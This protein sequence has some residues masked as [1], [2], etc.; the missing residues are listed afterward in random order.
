[1]EE[2]ESAGIKDKNLFTNL[3]YMMNMGYLTTRSTTT[4]SPETT[5]TSSS[6]SNKLC[7][8][9]VSDSMFEIRK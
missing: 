7:N 3:K 1:M 9:I 2:L 8:N 6:L 4:S 5:T